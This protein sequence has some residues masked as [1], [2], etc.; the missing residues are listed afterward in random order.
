ML[1]KPGGHLSQSGRFKIVFV[2]LLGFFG[3]PGFAALCMV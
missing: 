3:G 1:Y 2:F